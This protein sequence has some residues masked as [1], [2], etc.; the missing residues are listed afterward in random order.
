M[1]E[2]KTG[3]GW[4]STGASLWVYRHG[5]RAGC[6]CFPASP[7]SIQIPCPPRQ[8][9]STYE[10]ILSDYPEQS[11]NL[12]RCGLP[13]SPRGLAWKLKSSGSIPPEDAVYGSTSQT[14]AT[15]NNTLPHALTCEGKHFIPN[16]YRGWTGHYLN[17]QWENMRLWFRACRSAKVVLGEW[18]PKLWFWTIPLGTEVKVRAT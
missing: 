17:N 6:W 18:S 8:G 12:A 10:A 5:T 4:H 16:T 9:L 11:M 3:V 13:M 7:H 2:I 1:V 14:H 15:S